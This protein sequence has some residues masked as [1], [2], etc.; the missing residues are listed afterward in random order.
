MT[1]TKAKGTTSFYS[2]DQFVRDATS[3]NI[4]MANFQERL[5]RV[6]ETTGMN[7]SRT[8]AYAASL[9][10]PD[11]TEPGS[12]P[13]RNVTRLDPAVKSAIESRRGP[14]YV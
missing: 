12:K 5:D 6:K 7:E 9:V 14:D 3:G 8:L 2:A 10:L 13:V 1:D 11:P 4:T